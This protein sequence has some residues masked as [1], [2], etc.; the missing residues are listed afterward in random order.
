VVENT[1]LDRDNG[2]MSHITFPTYTVH[3]AEQIV[4]SRRIQLLPARSPCVFA[5]EGG[6]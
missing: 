6:T 1:A 3:Q 4:W 5:R 2:E